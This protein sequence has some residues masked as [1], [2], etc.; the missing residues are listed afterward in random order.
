MFRSRPIAAH[1]AA[2]AVLVVVVASC[3]RTP[4]GD[5]ATRGERETPTATVAVAVRRDVSGPL[6]VPAELTGGAADDSRNDGARDARPPRH[7]LAA[8]PND[9]DESEREP[10]EDVIPVMSTPAGSADV[11]QT[12]FGTK[13]PARLVASFDGLGVGFTGPQGTANDAQPVRQHARRRPRSHRADREHAHGDLH[14]EGQAVRHDR[15]RCCTARARRATCSRGSAA[16]ARRATTATPSCATT[17]SR[18][19]G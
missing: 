15:A 11:E 2:T 14:E 6:S 13:P 8:E 9:E 7:A 19:A 12:T 10:A 4:P 5:L 17:S 16:G 1:L 3:E 18:I